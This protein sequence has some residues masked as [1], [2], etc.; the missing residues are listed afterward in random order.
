MDEDGEWKEQI[1]KVKMTFSL[2]GNK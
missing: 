2:V 1:I